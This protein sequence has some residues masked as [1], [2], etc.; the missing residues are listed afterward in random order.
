MLPS[1]KIQAIWRKSW[2]LHRFKLRLMTLPSFRLQ[3]FLWKSWFLQHFTLSLMTLPSL[4]IQ[5]IWRKSWFFTTFQIDFDDAPE[6]QDTGNLTN[7]LDFHYASNWVWWRSQASRCRHSY[8][9]CNFY[10]ISQWVWWRS[11]A[12]SCRHSHKNRDFSQH[13]TLSLMTLP[14]PKIRAIW[15]KL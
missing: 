11:R 7:R 15:R 2:F 3:A 4:K 5:A 9:N 10:I 14:S 6:L 1:F 13:F 12:L 8:E